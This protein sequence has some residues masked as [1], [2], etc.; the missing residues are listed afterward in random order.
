MYV[1]SINSPTVPRGE[2]ML[3]I[4]PSPYHTEEQQKELIEALTDVFQKLGLPIGCGQASHAVAG[5]SL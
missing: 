2:E 5:G 1:Q 4:T 3:R